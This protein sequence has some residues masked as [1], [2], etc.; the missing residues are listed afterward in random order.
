MPINKRIEE[1]FS[2]YPVFTYRDVSLYVKKGRNLA[3]IISHMKKGGKLHT[4]AKGVYTFN[5]DSIVAGFAY[6]PFYYGMLS[7]LTIRELWTQESRPDIMTLRRVRRSRRSIFG[8]ADDV[9]FVHHVPAKYFFGFDLV[10]HGR[11]IVPVSDPEKTLID[12]FYYRVRLPMQSYDGL[13]R[14]I[15]RRKLEAYLKKYDRRTAGKA[16]AFVKEYM[17]AALSGRLKSPY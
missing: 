15:N 13:L 14:A 17:P 8:N 3:R 11:F 1:K 2:S 6:R 9:V 10:K 12:L 4:V 7:A 5:R 16:L